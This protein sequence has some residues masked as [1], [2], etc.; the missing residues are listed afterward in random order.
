MDRISDSGS[1]DLG[2]NPDGVTFTIHGG[3]RN[4]ATASLLLI[5]TQLGQQKP[6]CAAIKKSGLLSRI[7]TVYS[8]FFIS[9]R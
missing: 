4:I 9:E 3:C 5:F 2:S 6:Y 7:V 1:D 8:T